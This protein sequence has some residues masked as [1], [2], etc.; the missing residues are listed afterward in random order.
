[1]EVNGSRSVEERIEALEES[2]AQH[3]YNAGRLAVVDSFVTRIDERLTT[4]ELA[5]K[6]RDVKQE[7]RDEEQEKKQIA[8]QTSMT[9]VKESMTEMKV[10]FRGSS[11]TLDVQRIPSTTSGK[12]TV[13]L[14][15][16]LAML[17]SI[18]QISSAMGW[19]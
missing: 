14:M 9:E 11:S 12:L 17:T 18:Q 6:D 10:M 5:Q 15:A 3:D 19:R 1:M 2:S 8:L 4:F 16:L 7:R 13:V